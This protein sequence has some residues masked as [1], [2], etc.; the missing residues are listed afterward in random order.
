MSSVTV[1]TFAG[2]AGAAGSTNGVGLA[3][4]FNNPSGIAMDAA[5]TFMIVVSGAFRALYFVQFSTASC[6]LAL[7]SVQ[8][9]SSNH[10]LRRIDIASQTVTTYAGVA[11][12][13]GTANGVGV[14]ALFN[15]PY[16]IA[17]NPTGTVA[18]VVSRATREI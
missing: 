2:T 14:A 10:L 16:S 1:T 7:T 6:L 12:T 11:G 13:A 18:I 9:D 17:M 3:A 15:T 8:G 5:A 4:R